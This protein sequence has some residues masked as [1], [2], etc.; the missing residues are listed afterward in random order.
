VVVNGQAHHY[1]RFALQDP[2]GLEDAARGIRQFVVG[3][4]GRKLDGFG[5]PAANSEVRNSDTHGVIKF[6]LRQGSYEWQ[7]V[8]V[9]G[10]TFTDSGSHDC[11]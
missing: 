2:N 5:M 11:H 8:P 3:T 9:A 1:E 6:T 10:K 4:G 7:F